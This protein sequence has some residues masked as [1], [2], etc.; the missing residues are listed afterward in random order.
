MQ[1]KQEPDWT[2][3]DAFW[4]DAWADMQQRLDGNPVAKKR[5]TG[6]WWLTG[7]VL[8]LLLA[9]LS[10]LAWADTANTVELP[11]PTAVPTA[12]APVTEH[13]VATA[14][15]DQPEVSQPGTASA[16]NRPITT[17]TINAST[18]PTAATTPTAPT[19]P[20]VATKRALAQRVISGSPTPEGKT[21]STVGEA[22]QPAPPTLLLSTTP[23]SRAPAPEPE[24]YILPTA[25]PS[26][27]ASPQNAVV[28]DLDALPTTA[29]L[30]SLS[31]AAA[32]LADLEIVRTPRP[33]RVALSM[34]AGTSA[35]VTLGNSGYFLGLGADVP[36]GKRF[37]LPVS[38]R[39]R[40]DR[41]ALGDYP[42]GGLFA[43]RADNLA[44]LIE[45]DSSGL[46]APEYILNFAEA[47]LR[48][49]AIDL[50]V[51]L[52]WRA[53]RRLHLNAGL[54]VIYNT[55]GSLNNIQV[56]NPDNLQADRLT[57]LSTNNVYVENG[58]N[59]NLSS[60]ASDPLELLDDQRLLSPRRWLYRLHFGVAFH[61]TPRLAV[62]TT[63]NQLLR[64]FDDAKNV[65]VQ[66]V[67][68][69]IGGKYRLR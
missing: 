21:T 32:H 55:L 22:S 60:V 29:P 65:G 42:E 46:S 24:Q 26:A 2:A 44:D 36:L 31:N 69:E 8:L 13:L 43:G 38:L 50:G 7:G 67:Q 4:D 16:Q 53:S 47:T 59:F 11:N 56:I 10:W 5:A 63:L 37:S 9:G 52:Q 23:A 15:D 14:T 28:A 18:A 58:L 68:L 33:G 39:Y 62:T 54:N 27:P 6:W 48:N 41:L 1:A 57:G 19:T 66:Q 40:Q 51:G 49:Q 3:D 34:L 17:T 64:Q 12:P 61:L 45:M 25:S 20:A 35:N 30:S